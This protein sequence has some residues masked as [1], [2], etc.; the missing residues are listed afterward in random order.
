M[1]GMPFHDYNESLSLVG[2]PGMFASCGPVPFARLASLLLVLP[3][4]RHGLRALVQQYAFRCGVVLEVAVEVDSLR[5]LCDIVAGG[6]GYTVLPATALAGRKDLVAVPI[7]DPVP[8]RS[9]VLARSRGDAP[10][11]AA[12]AVMGLIRD[13]LMATEPSGAGA[14]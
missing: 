11:S 7:V 5:A 3:G 9:L 10:D 14:D 8:S 1:Q 13:E 2:A 4:V 6:E 12:T